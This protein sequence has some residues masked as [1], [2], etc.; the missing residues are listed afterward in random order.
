MSLGYHS[1]IYIQLH[2][3]AMWWMIYFNYNFVYL[4]LVLTNNIERLNFK[5]PWGPKLFNLVLYK[6][7]HY[8]YPLSNR[9]MNFKYFLDYKKKNHW[10]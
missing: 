5:V 10:K 6:Y 3:S 8:E 1:R 2:S 9:Q 4:L 7:L